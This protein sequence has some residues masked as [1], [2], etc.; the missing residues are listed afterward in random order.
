MR[1]PTDDF[2][3]IKYESMRVVD[4]EIG[5]SPHHRHVQICRYLC[6]SSP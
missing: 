2:G 1:R 4:S 5:Q 3:L 6:A